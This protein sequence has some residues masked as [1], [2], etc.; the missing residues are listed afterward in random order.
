MANPRSKTPARE[1]LPVMSVRCIISLVLSDPYV[2][3][4]Y[5]GEVCVLPPIPRAELAQIS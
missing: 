1:R 5:D 2:F 3:S 4:V